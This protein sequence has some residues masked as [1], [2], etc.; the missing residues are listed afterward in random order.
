MLYSLAIDNMV[1][2]PTTQHQ[3]LM[4]YTTTLQWGQLVRVV[5]SIHYFHGTEN[6]KEASLGK[7]LGFNSR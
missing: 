4:S 1:N 6:I 7:R 5:P 2:N 3:Q